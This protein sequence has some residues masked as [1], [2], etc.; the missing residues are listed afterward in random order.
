M[1]FS[2]HSDSVNEIRNALNEILNPTEFVF[3]GL[4]EYEDYDDYAYDA[5]GNSY[6]GES[7]EYDDLAFDI[8]SLLEHETIVGE[9]EYLYESGQIDE[10]E[11]EALLAEASVFNSGGRVPNAVISQIG[12]RHGEQYA[13]KDETNSGMH[14]PS[15]AGSA[16]SKSNTDHDSHVVLHH[17]ETGKF[18]GAY[19]KTRKDWRTNI[20]SFHH[21]DEDGNVTHV[22]NGTDMRAHLKDTLGAHGVK[23]VKLTAF[24]SNY[25][26]T[27]SPDG[28]KYKDESGSAV[29]RLRNDRNYKTRIDSWKDKSFGGIRNRAIDKFIHKT[30]RAAE[31]I[32]FDHDEEKDLHSHHADL[33]KALKS[34]NTKAAMD[35][36]SDYE[37]IVRQK[38]HQSNFNKPAFKQ[39]G[40]PEHDAAQKLSWA[41]DRGH[42]A[43]DA[44]QN[45][46]NRHMHTLR[47]EHGNSKRVQTVDNYRMPEIADKMRKYKEINR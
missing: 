2:T 12:R 46:N 22:G 39:Y 1:T 41:A 29:S 17:P 14:N 33:I 5:L 18:L 27:K 43:D 9:I 3:E 30:G 10:Y 28:V 8:E 45:T 13:F 16:I 23:N 42:H 25:A 15:T 44:Q 20:K 31:A 19:F 47:A 7:T 38:H 37:R 40:T 4:D 26:G 24:R 21:I 11:A 36:L 6:L 32:G 34:G 35:K